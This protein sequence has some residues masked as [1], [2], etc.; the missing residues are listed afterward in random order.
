MGGRSVPIAIIIS[1]R[2]ADG[3]AIPV[4]MCCC[5]VST[6][7]VVGRRGAGGHPILIAMSTDRVSVTV[8]IP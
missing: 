5:G 3:L 6:A 7:V 4:P 2:R 1:L 8:V